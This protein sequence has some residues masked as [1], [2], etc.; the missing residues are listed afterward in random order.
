MWELWALGK[1]S[2]YISFGRDVES[3]TIASHIYVARSKMVG[4]IYGDFSTYAPRVYIYLAICITHLTK[5]FL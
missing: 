4:W 3:R 5:N 2:D 1:R